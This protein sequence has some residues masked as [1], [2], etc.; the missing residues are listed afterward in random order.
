ME[1]LAAIGWTVYDRIRIGPLE[2]SPHG[3][4]IAVGYLAGSWWMLR[5]GPKRGVSEDH[6]GSILL[7]A[8][9]GAIIGAR[10][11]YVIGHLSDFDNVAQM[12]E[13][14]KGGISLIGGI[15]GAVIATYPL[16]RKYKYR[17]LQVMDSAAIGLA[18]GIFIGRI[19][20][21]IIG[22]HLGKPTSFFLGF[23]YKGGS[24]PGY[25]CVGEAG[26]SVCSTTLPNGATQTIRYGDIVH[27]TALYDF[28]VA[29]ILFGLLWWMNRKPR[30]EGTL[31]LTFAILYGANRV[32]TDFLRVDKT[33]F[34]L[35]GTQITLLAVILVSLVTLIRRRG[36]PVVPTGPGTPVTVGAKA[37]AW[38]RDDRPL[39]EFTPPPDPAA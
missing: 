18:F 16:V 38:D 1:Y 23:Q 35:T 25:A 17:F 32:I 21:L 30:R 15:S 7:W 34:G 33:Y 8:L 9:I 3:I 4:G 27:Q 29:G 2:I 19:G 13:V 14:W 39:T 11:F 12:F 5:E 10:F 22:D 26:V 37:G 36:R 20:D 6:V 31:F 24:L 28:L